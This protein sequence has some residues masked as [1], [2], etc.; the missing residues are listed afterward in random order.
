MGIAHCTLD[1][2]LPVYEA[3]LDFS[4]IGLQQAFN[5]TDF[6]ESDCL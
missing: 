4:L 3:Q 2:D 1:T 5:Q 6:N